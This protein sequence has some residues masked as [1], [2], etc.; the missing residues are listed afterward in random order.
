MRLPWCQKVGF[1]TISSPKLGSLSLPL[2]DDSPNIP[3]WWTKN[4][5]YCFV[6]R[7]FTE[8]LIILCRHLWKL[9]FWWKTRIAEF[10]LYNTLSIKEAKF[11]LILCLLPESLASWKELLKNLDSWFVCQA[12]TINFQGIDFKETYA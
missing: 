2:R 10:K 7:E 11:H 3:H 4:L 8:I 5:K 12:C 9:F 6:I 1:W